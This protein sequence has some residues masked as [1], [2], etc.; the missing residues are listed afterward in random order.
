MDPDPAVPATPP[1]GSVSPP[2]PNVDREIA[3]LAV[4]ALGALAAEPL[5]LLADTAIVGRLGTA[6]LGGLAIAAMVLVATFGIFNFLAYATTAAVARQVGAGDRR[7]AAER[8]LDGIW[9]AAGL[10][11]TLTGLGL[12]FAPLIVDAMGASAR[13][14]PEA[15][16]YLRISVLG[17]PMVLVALAGAGYL[18]GLQDTKTTLLIAATAAAANVVI[19]LWLVFGLDLGIA[20]SAW[21]TVAAQTG[22]AAAFVA[23]VHRTARAAGARLAPRPAGIRQ[24]AV[25]GSHLVVRTGSLLA[26]LLGTTAVAAR[27][28]DAALAGH[29]I[30][31]QLWTFLALVLDALAIAAQ[32]MVGRAL[33]A[34]DR[35]AAL[36]VARRTLAWGLVAGL[37]LGLAVAAARPGLL[38]LFTADPQVRARAADALWWVAALQPVAAATFVLDG[39][40]IGA[41]DSRFLARAMIVAL[42]VYAPLLSAVALAGAGLPVL[43]AAFSGWM[44]ARLAGLAWRYRS[45]RWARTGAVWDARP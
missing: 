18:R 16:T 20:G 22:A 30:A 39:V 38:P 27:I 28:S 15:L 14:R 24:T 31:F 11:L 33:G 6:P 32:A 37:V 7:A 34:G 17:A 10:G 2:P 21:S 19:E 42:V 3:R 4:P 29:Q 25:V 12:A 40:L 5:Y 23:V 26:A 43:W 13:V 9:L 35:H 44:A 45:R 8:G 1:S 41:G 36:A